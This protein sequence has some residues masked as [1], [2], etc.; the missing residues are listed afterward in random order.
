M[1]IIHAGQPVKYEGT[2][3]ALGNFDGLHTA[4][5]TIIRSCI[6]Y[7][8]N[9]G[10]KSGV[11]LFNEHTKNSRL[12][13]TNEMKLELLRREKPDFVYLRSFTE[14][15]MQKTPRE[16]ALLLKE[17][18]HIK[19][20]CIGYDYR[21]GHRAEGD[22][23]LLK[24][25]GNELDFEVLVT[26]KISMDGY[27]VHCAYIRSLIDSGD[28]ERANA[29]L[30]RRYSL[31]GA[32]EYGLQNGRKM[33]IPTANIGY[34]PRMLLPDN[35]V[36]AGAVYVRGKSFKCVINVGKNPTFGADKVTVEV[37]ILDFD[38]DI[39]GENIRAEFVK[40][41]RGDIKFDGMAAL[42]AQIQKDIET[43]RRMNIL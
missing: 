9:E 29:L 1:E 5:M 2:A 28:I 42:K 30:G 34:D 19:A 36:Y 24:K 31:E 27:G 18:L 12:I 7:A 13:T 40:R 4:H 10:L 8:R 17:N 37:H 21:F 43:T 15:F 20:V 23:E 32:V 22:A 14:E 35:G 33:G 16:F 38:E 39:Y 41:L 11:L 3:V 6:E 25:F 26:P